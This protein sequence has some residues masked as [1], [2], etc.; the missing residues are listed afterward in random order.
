MWKRNLFMLNQ[1]I[2]EWINVQK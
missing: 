1:I 2:E